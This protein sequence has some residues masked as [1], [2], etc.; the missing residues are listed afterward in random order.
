VP[1]P[2]DILRQLAT[3][4]QIEGEHQDSF[5]RNLRFIFEI[6]PEWHRFD[7]RARKRDAVKDQLSKVE[8]AIA[9]L[10]GELECLDSGARR[11]L[12]VAVLRHKEFGASQ[13]LQEHIFET[14]DQIRLGD[15]VVRG[16]ELLGTCLDALETLRAATSSYQFQGPA[17]RGAP[18]KSPAVA[19]NPKTTAEDLFILEVHRLAN[20]HGGHL[21]LDKN[22]RTGTA[23]EFL[24]LA[25]RYLPGTFRLK[26]FS[27]RRLQEL[28][29]WVAGQK[30]TRK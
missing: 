19:G 27:T 25:S 10:Q 21:T 16:E 30:P 3:L 4:A 29:K 11:A 14:D 8:K 6:A 24:Q 5:I 26:G 13:S 15:G 22:A 12:G 18:T 17:R 23:M 28:R 20:L 9:R 7:Q 1:P 2:E